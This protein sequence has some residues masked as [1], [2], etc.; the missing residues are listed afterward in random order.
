[1]FIFW[2]HL[3][4][5]WPSYQRLGQQILS[6]EVRVELFQSFQVGNIKITKINN[7][8]IVRRNF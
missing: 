5:V 4:M 3:V 1:M 8:V 7:P 6:L 2:V